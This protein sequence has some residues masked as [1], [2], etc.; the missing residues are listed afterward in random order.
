MLLPLYQGIGEDGF[1]LAREVRR[2][3]LRVS[4]L[5]RRLGIDELVPLLPGIQ[6][7][8]LRP[9]LSGPGSQPPRELVV[10]RRVARAFVRRFL[11]LLGYRPV[12]GGAEGL[13][14]R[15]RVGVPSPPR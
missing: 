1:F 2:G 9:A 13:V 6:R 5:L 12:S 10:D 7:R 15:L 3:W 11:H 4:S 14:F 8:E